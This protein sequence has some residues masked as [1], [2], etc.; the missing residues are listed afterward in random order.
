VLRGIDGVLFVGRGFLVG[1]VIEGGLGVVLGGFGE[2]VCL[3]V[4]V[5]EGIVK[6]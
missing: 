5:S 4:A 3:L 2:L 6:G 1:A